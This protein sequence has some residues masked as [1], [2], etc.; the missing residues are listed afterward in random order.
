MA[1]RRCSVET[2][3]SFR[4]S[5][6]SRARLI[7][8]SKRGEAYC[9]PPLPRTVGSLSTSA[10]TWR[11]S[12]SGRAPSL[13]RSGPTTP[14]CCC[15]SASSRCS[16]SMAWWLPWSARDWAA[17]IASWALTV[18]LSILI[19]VGLRSELLQ[20]LE[21]LFFFRAEP[22]RDHDLY[23]HEL[24][25]G[26]AAL[27]MRHPVAAEPEGLAAGGLGRDLHRDLALQRRHRDLA[28]ERGRRHRQRQV[29][30]QVGALALE[31]GV[32]GHRHAQ[33]EIPAV[34]P[35][36]APAARP[37]R[38][39]PHPRAGVHAGRDLHVQVPGGLGPA[40]ALA[41]RAGAALHVAGPATLGA[42]LVE[43]E[44][45]G[46]ARAVEGLLERQLDGRLHVAAAPHAATQVAPRVT[47]AREPARVALL[48]E[49]DV[50]T[51]EGAAL[52]RG[53]PPC[54]GAGAS[55]S[56]A[57]P[58]GAEGVVALALLRIGKDRVS[59][60][61]LLEAL[62][63]PLV[64]IRVVLAGELA[65]GGLDRLVVGPALDPEGLVVVFEFHVVRRQSGAGLASPRRFRRLGEV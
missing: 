11:V 43:L 30:V 63:V 36:A 8:P 50:S 9:R 20:L 41:A 23:L 25:A 15:R 53:S 44:R 31:A 27:E 64:D 47:K 52:E 29:Q 51:P 22:A 5:A 61:D 6:S 3:S 58:V 13:P 35:I 55:L 18:S 59:L 4:R 45:D 1:I 54:R 32:G 37:L 39:H 16:G 28:P 10:W 12:A 34:A 7:T 62:R 26:P 57:L 19:S 48:G 46:L 40:A 49:A 21:E 17:W 42:R 33:V 14:S 60:A 56:I 2:Y 65:V 38:R 24:V